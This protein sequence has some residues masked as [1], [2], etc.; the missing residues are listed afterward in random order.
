MADNEIGEETPGGKRSFLDD[1]R[2]AFR[3]KVAKKP[4]PLVDT[5]G[6]NE[7]TDEGGVPV[8]ALE[9]ERVD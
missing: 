5:D 2:L 7:R 1:E 4:V 9:L 8:A 3:P 6:T